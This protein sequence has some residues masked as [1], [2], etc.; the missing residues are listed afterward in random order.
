MYFLANLQNFGLLSLHQSKGSSP[1][2]KASSFLYLQTI[3]YWKY[4]VCQSITCL[5]QPQVHLLPW[6]P[7]QTRRSI[8]V[9]S[10]AWRAA[11]VLPSASNLLWVLEDY[12]LEPSKYRFLVC[13]LYGDYPAKECHHYWRHKFVGSTCTCTL[14]TYTFNICENHHFINYYCWAGCTLHDLHQNSKFS[15]LFVL[16]VTQ[17]SRTLILQTLR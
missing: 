4:Q 16:H 14:L 7:H 3:I 15:Q 10:W 12:F 17:A 5:A 9:F 13:R 2:P 6:Y 1:S 11:P 8:P